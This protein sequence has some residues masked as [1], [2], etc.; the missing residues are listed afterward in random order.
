MAREKESVRT[1]GQ[2]AEAKTG[3]EA[4]KHILWSG[5]VDVGEGQKVYVIEWGNKNGNPFM[6]LHGGPGQSFN[7]SHVALF[8][9]E[10][11]HVIFFDQR[12]CGESSPS[13][14]GMKKE[15]IEKINTPFHIIS[16]MEKLRT[17]FELEKM[18]VAGGSW[19]S[20]LALL[21]AIEHPEKTASLAMWSMY[22]GTKKET[23]GLFADQT[24]DSTF[25]YTKEWERFV[26][27][28]PP[29]ERG[30]GSDGLVDPRQ[31]LAYYKKMVNSSDKKVAQKF[32][33]EY[34][35][36]EFTLCAPDDPSTI[37][38]YVV[39][40]E[41]AIAAARIETLYLS[42]D[43]FIPEGYILDNIDRIKGIP[44]LTAQGDRDRCTPIQ[45]ARKFEEALGKECVIEVKNAGH[46]RDDREMKP[47]L[48]RMMAGAP[49]VAPVRS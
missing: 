38:S 5:Y 27:M 15:E 34:A 14:G 26:G 24:G 31:V 4:V 22:L 40:D 29:Q 7:S 10:T 3:K 47:V 20:T 8:N 11:D 16:D 30:K 9:P 19:G 28:V 39:G 2:I 33:E 49:N 18:N 48:Q 36:Y 32:A 43:L 13:A 25:L 6:C 46:L 42:N 35:M 1:P 44:M 17:K 37:E 21:Y 12:G 41:N 45:H 23:E